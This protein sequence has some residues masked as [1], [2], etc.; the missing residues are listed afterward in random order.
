M[1]MLAA[2]IAGI[3]MLS[4]QFGQSN[5]H[6]T[7]AE[8]LDNVDIY[9]VK[10]DDSLLKIGMKY[11]VSELELKKINHKKTDKIYPGEKL[12]LPKSITNEEKDLLA[13]LVHAEAKGEPY[14]GKVAVALVVLNRVEDD[15]FPDTIKDVIY[16]ER[17]FE[18]VD[19][20]SINEPADQEAQKAVMEALALQ[21]QGN[22]SV[23]FYNPD[24]VSNTWLSTR[25]ATMVIGNHQF[26]K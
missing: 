4:F 21:G 26:A 9:T 18:P 13:R 3:I 17:Q 1:K 23:Y 16:E 24:K 7:Y 2:F 12:I 5:N 11:G 15:R 10:K 20:G 19:N 6:R 22:D 8:T 25:T 14:E